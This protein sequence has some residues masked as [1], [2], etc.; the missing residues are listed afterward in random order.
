[1]IRIQC[2]TCAG[3]G[4]RLVPDSLCDMRRIMQLAFRKPV[5]VFVQ[6]L[7]TEDDQ[8]F[9]SILA[10]NADEALHIEGEPERVCQPAL[11]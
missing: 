5:I 6:G 10:Q 7:K 3:F 1:M 8:A 11:F 9:L 4:V 2:A